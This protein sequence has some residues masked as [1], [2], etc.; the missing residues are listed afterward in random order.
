MKKCILVILLTD[1]IAPSGKGSPMR[2]QIASPSKCA[3]FLAA[4]VSTMLIWVHVAQSCEISAS[5]NTPSRQIIACGDAITIER[6]P[7]AALEITKRPNDPAPRV[8]EVRGGAILIKVTPGHTPTQV[9][10]PHAI[11]T[12]RGT[13][14]VVDA[15]AEQT[16]VFVL[17]GGVNV[18]RTNDASTVTLNAGEGTDVSL[19]EPLSVRIWEANR[20]AELLA[21]FGR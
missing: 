21:R 20:A 11:A 15:G 8:I 4:F 17:E 3:T 13:T 14:Y 10:T 16:S 9:R 1:A 18:R 5:E 6:E 2:H 12:V 7:A 19:D